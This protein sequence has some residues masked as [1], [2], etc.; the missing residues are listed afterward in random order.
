MLLILNPL[1][2]FISLIQELTYLIIFVGKK[3]NMVIKLLYTF[4]LC[5]FL[6]S[7]AQILDTTFGTA[8][9][10]YT[11]PSTAWDSAGDIFVEQ[12]NSLVIL[13]NIGPGTKRAI[14]K[15]DAGGNLVTSFGNNGITISQNQASHSQIIKLSSGKY[16]TVGS[17]GYMYNQNF[18]AE[19][20]NTDGTLDTSFGDNGKAAVNMGYPATVETIDMAYTAIE[21]PDGKII[22]CGW[23]EYGYPKKRSCLLKLNQDGTVDTTF[24]TNGKLYF[25]LNPGASQERANGMNIFLWDNKIIVSGTGRI[26]DTTENTT[27]INDMYVVR[28]NLNGTYDTTFGTNG[29]LIFNLGYSSEY[30]TALQ[31][32]NGYTYITGSVYS[33]SVS[34]TW[35]AKISPQGQLVANFGNNGI[36]KRK[37]IPGSQY[38]VPKT[39]ALGN[40]GIYVGGNFYFPNALSNYDWMYI[41]KFNFDGTPDL[42]F[43]TNGLFRL[44]GDYTVRR[45]FG[46]K[47]DNNKRLVVAGDSNHSDRQ[48]ASARI[49]INGETLST[50]DI[51]AA[52]SGLHFYPNPVSDFLH[53][54]VNNIKSVQKIELYSMDG[55][56]MTGLDYTPEG[57]ILKINLQNI[58]AGSYV[59]KIVCGNRMQIVKISKK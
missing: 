41:G 27:G 20:F 13:G 15:L 58:S 46:M 48:F 19:R 33:N 16:L 10:N 17:V 22:L 25:T 12:D 4:S 2:Y 42:T 53:V 38:E 35:V 55:R 37:I 44:P 43:G 30:G 59:L 8:G 26:T 24:G 56:M 11:N 40:N 50:E 49:K 54:Q 7:N 14:Y 29:K 21:L 6:V 1:H 51:K 39:I 5:S 18:F 9:Y 52:N 45:L 32:S 31:D 23:A 34:E 28:L 36:T 47:F 57:N 3:L